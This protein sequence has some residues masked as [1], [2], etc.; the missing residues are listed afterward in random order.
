METCESFHG[1]LAEIMRESSRTSNSF[2]REATLLWAHTTNIYQRENRIVIAQM[3]EYIIMA[4]FRVPDVDYIWRFVAIRLC[5]RRTSRL[6]QQMEKT[7]SIAHLSSCLS[8]GT[9]LVDGTAFRIPVF[10]REA[11]HPY[12]Y[13]CERPCCRTRRHFC[14]L[15]CV[16][17]MCHFVSDAACEKES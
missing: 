14:P 6:F 17:N 3:P 15:V 2:L 10:V 16:L 12:L 1:A 5:F 8:K 9:A 13:C 7:G 4:T 11:Y